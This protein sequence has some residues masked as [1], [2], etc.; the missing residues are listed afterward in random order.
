MLHAATLGCA[1]RSFAVV[2][3]G[4]MSVMFADAVCRAR[5]HVR[6]HARTRASCRAAAAAAASLCCCSPNVVV[7]QPFADNAAPA[8]YNIKQFKLLVM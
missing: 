8:F 2:A 1:N 6:M 3:N 5:T 7:A 4:L